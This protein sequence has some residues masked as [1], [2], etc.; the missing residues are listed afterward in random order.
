MM[1]AVLYF[2]KEKKTNSLFVLTS[3]FGFNLRK[4]F[5]RCLVNYK[6]AK[7]F[8]FEQTRGGVGPLF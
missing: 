6:K 1:F 2:P 5:F 4:V 3:L 8:G 7:N